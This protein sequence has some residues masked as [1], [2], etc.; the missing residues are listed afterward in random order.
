MANEFETALEGLLNF[1]YVD[2][3]SAEQYNILFKQMISA[4]MQICGETDFAVIIN[5]KT[6]D[7]QKKYGVKME[8]SE[9]DADLYRKL[10]DVV[11]F[12]MNRE[13]ILN[14]KEYELCCTESNFKNAESR[15]RGE[16][17][18]IVPPGQMEVLDSMTHSI[19][20]D[21]TKFFVS[22]VLD[23]IADAKIYQLA[24]FRPLQL[25]ALG[26]EVRTYVN[27]IKQQNAKPQKSQVVTDWFRSVMLLPAFLF[28][29]QYGVSFVE[30]F[31]V[32]QKLVDDAAHTYNVFQKT[33]ESF[34]A[35][36][37]YIILHDLL[38]VMNISDCFTIR[39]KVSKAAESRGTDQKIN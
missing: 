24:E 23:M 34:C 35:G 15:F 22:T 25:N 3:K 32:P 33:F 39:P 16:L 4:S 26:K 30:M 29:K 5:Q 12:E 7:A 37:E 17:E 38:R 10:R 21:F 20:S 36:D 27:V 1:K 19:Y 6:E 11:R 13:S 18:K 28:K 9:D 14:N 31:D 2:A 8:S